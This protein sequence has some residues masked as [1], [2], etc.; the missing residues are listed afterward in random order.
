MIHLP[1]AADLTVGNV[2]SVVGVPVSVL[3]A[4]SGMEI[5]NSIDSMLRADIN[6]PVKV[7]EAGLFEDTRVHVI[8]E[9]H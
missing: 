4:R 1:T 3:T 2:A 7:L 9:A 6:D 5:E 8:L